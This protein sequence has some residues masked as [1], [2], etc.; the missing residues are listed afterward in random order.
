MV[1]VMLIMMGLV[2]VG[3]VSGG[4]CG[5]GDDAD[6]TDEGR[7]GGEGVRSQEGRSRLNRSTTPAASS[8]THFYLPSVCVIRSSIRPSYDMYWKRR[9][10][11][12]ERR[13][14]GQK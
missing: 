1:L 3:V 10:G 8:R 13:K 2:V 6:V 11:A 5:G 9:K 12:R 7:R 4:S 14:E